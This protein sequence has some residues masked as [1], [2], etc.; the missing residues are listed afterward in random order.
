MNGPPFLLAWHSFRG[1]GQLAILSGPPA[2]KETV[3]RLAV[4]PSGEDGAAVNGHAV[5]TSPGDYSRPVSSSASFMRATF[6]AKSEPI[7]SRSG[8]VGNDLLASREAI[9]GNAY[10]RDT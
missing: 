2:Y 9:I 6:P 4:W 8:L 3:I 7:G 5:V 1:V 10:V